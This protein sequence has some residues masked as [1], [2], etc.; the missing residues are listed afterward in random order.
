MLSRTKVAACLVSAGALVGPAI[1]STSAHADVSECAP[2]TID[3]QAIG[4]IEL[5]GQP[6]QQP[7]GDPGLDVTLSVQI[8]GQQPMNRS[9]SAV[10]PVAEAQQQVQQ[11]VQNLCRASGQRL[12]SENELSFITYGH[13]YGV[14]VVR[15]DGVGA[16]YCA[17]VLGLTV[18]DG[19]D[20]QPVSVSPPGV[21][22]TP[23]Q[24]VTIPYH[25]PKVC[26]TTAPGLCLGPID[27]TLS[28]TVPE[29]GI[30]QPT[31]DPGTA[32]QFCLGG[33]YTDPDVGN[34]AFRLYP[35]PFPT[36]PT[37]Y[38]FYDDRNCTPYVPLGVPPP[39]M[40]V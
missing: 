21:T 39:T 37:V 15:Q 35:D 30:Q 7:N 20:P 29:P 23:I 9:V 36:S 38:G 34:S 13:T 6:T 18:V 26:V 16:S 4:C 17:G 27:G 19:R 25:V 40:P 11:Q 10:L 8:Y 31:V 12:Q 22:T 5:A 3:D 28:P 24:P 2:I 32:T 1:V 14:G 33:P